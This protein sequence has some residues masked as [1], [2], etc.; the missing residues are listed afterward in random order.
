M[1]AF[2]L[3]YRTNLGVLPRVTGL[4]SRRRNSREAQAILD[5]PTGHS[6]VLQSSKDLPLA[7]LR[8][9]S[10]EAR[11]APAGVHVVAEGLVGGTW[12]VLE[13]AA[14]R[15]GG[16]IRGVGLGELE[17][18]LGGDVDLLTAGDCDAL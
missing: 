3:I 17:G 14:G 15:A 12:H 18:A 11:S 7:I 8:R 16:N 1:Y 4:V 10:H 2:H 13:W 6:G 5:I 9:A